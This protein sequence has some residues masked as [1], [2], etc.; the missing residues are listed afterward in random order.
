MWR[1]LWWIAT[2]PLQ[3]LLVVVVA[4]VVG[5]ELEKSVARRRRVEPVGDPFMDPCT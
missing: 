1:A 5:P 3:S 4:L 2:H